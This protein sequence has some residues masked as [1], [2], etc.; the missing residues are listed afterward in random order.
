[1]TN[2]IEQKVFSLSADRPGADP[3]VDRLGYA[4]FA[5]RLAESILRL[6]GAEGHVVA[7]YGPWGFGKTTML[8]Y[9]RYYVS[10]GDPVERP[11]IVPFNPWW[12]AGGEDL[13][14]AFFNQLRSLLEGHKE[15][16]SKMRNGLADFAELLSEAPLPHATLAK[17]GAR[18]IR[19]KPKNIA[20][21]KDE[22]SRALG[23]QGRN[24][25]VIIDDIDRLTSEEIRQIFRVVKAVADFPNVTY[26]MAFD[27]Q[28]V[29]RSLSELQGG[30][31]ED[32]LEKIVQVPFELP[33]V[34]RLSIRSFFFEKLNPVIAAV[35]PKNFD[36]VY[37]GN[38]FFEGIDKF[39]IT[40]RDVIRFAN[41]LAVTFQAVAGEVNPIDFIAIESLR[42]FVPEAYDCVRNNREMFCGSSPNDLRPP[43]SAELRK[44]HDE[45]LERLRKSSSRDEEP[46]K[47]LLKR[48]FPKLNGVWG[49]NQYGSDW[50]GRWRRALRV[51]SEDVFPVYFSLAVADGEISNSK[52]RAMLANAGD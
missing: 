51:C 50:E 36:Q 31:G 8:N 20:K 2:D 45:W 12:F 47:N 15:F 38:V 13:I 9:V 17:V 24:I 43:S 48:L 1:M 7:L 18:L 33:L 5:K 10:K 30:S 32:Y 4:P 42:M 16:S 19:P 44:F 34:D 35:D 37:W 49:N 52:M 26:L 46:V 6:S 27:K 29:A 41:T 40:P 22:I 14:S 21:L 28:V 3:E 39:L 25:L 11:I 23:I